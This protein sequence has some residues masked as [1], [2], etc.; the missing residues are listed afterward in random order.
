MIFI[1]FEDSTFI[2]SYTVP[3]NKSRNVIGI[4]IRLSRAG[5]SCL[6]TDHRDAVTEDLTIQ[7]HSVF[8][9]R[10]LKNEISV[11][12]KDVLFCYGVVGGG[13]QYS[14]DGRYVRS[15]QTCRQTAARSVIRGP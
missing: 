6:H 14:C 11:S 9:A 8:Q 13:V 5:M 2:M 15:A 10:S 1:S 12:Q 7:D 3:T 4:P